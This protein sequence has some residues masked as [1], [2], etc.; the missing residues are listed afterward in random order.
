ML[1]GGSVEP[2]IESLEMFGDESL[3]GVLPRCAIGADS[4][5]SGP[6]REPLV[7]EVDRSLAGAIL[8]S[9][10]RDAPNDEARLGRVSSLWVIDSIKFWPRT[11]PWNGTADNL[12]IESTGLFTGG[13]CERQSDRGR[14]WTSDLLSIRNSFVDKTS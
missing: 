5:V 11:I 1:F 12:L 9:L 14:V 3:G 7:S 6:W 13:L 4:G 2:R 8:N 10:R